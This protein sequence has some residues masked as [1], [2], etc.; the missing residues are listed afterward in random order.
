MKI[1]IGT[2]SKLKIRAVEA[3]LQKMKVSAEIIPQQTE[4]KVSDQPFGF[5]EVLE[6]AKNRAKDSLDS[7]KADMGIGIENGI[8]Y[9]GSINGWFDLPCVAIVTSSGQLAY[10]FGATDKIPDWM[11]DRIKKEKTELGFIIQELSGASE[12][13]PIAFFSDNLMR[14]EDIIAEAVACALF[15]IIN[16]K[17]YKEPSGHKS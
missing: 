11:I 9:Q 17:K 15:E 8:V 2:T 3:A 14:R 13:D 7:T 1:A 16:P 4:S 6:G 12:K 10:S 5:E